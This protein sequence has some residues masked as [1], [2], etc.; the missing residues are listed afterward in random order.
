MHLDA[1]P[2]G[3]GHAAPRIADRLATLDLSNPGA[4]LKKGFYGPPQPVPSP[5]P[6]DAP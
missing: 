2:Y 1:N 5:P 4:L 3:D 6:G